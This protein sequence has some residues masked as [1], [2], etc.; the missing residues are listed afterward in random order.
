M[1]KIKLT[2]NLLKSLIKNVIKEAEYSTATGPGLPIEAAA[3]EGYVDASLPP[4]E[5][6]EII[7]LLSTDR[8]SPDQKTE[9]TRLIGIH[10]PT[11]R[12]LQVFL[13]HN[14]DIFPA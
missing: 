1:K 5:K 14:P 3:A 6:E 12:A 4:E 8:T 13:R 10:G 7:S 11:S 2:Q 9:L